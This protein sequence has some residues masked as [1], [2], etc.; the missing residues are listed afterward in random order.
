[1]ENKPREFWIDVEINKPSV[2]VTN[3]WTTHCL[4]AIHVIEYSAFQALAAEN[5]R[6]REAMLNLVNTYQSSEN[7]SYDKIIAKIMAEILNS[8]AGDTM[9]SQLS[10]EEIDSKAHSMAVPML[11]DMVSRLEVYRDLV[12][13]AKWARAKMAEG[14]K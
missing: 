6:L 2:Q 14:K 11:R 1:M 13:I 4:E 3:V 7:V 5:Q 12:E 9:K 8:T 10:D